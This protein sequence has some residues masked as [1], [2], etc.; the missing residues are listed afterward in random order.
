[1]SQEAAIAAMRARPGFGVIPDPGTLER[2]A[3]VAL[4][5]RVRPILFDEPGA[6]M[7][8]RKPLILGVHGQE[9]DGSLLVS[10]IKID[11]P[12]EPD[13]YTDAVVAV[14][15]TIETVALLTVVGVDT[16]PKGTHLATTTSYQVANGGEFDGFPGYEFALLFAVHRPDADPVILGLSEDEIREQFDGKRLNLSTTE[17]RVYGEK[18]IERMPVL[19]VNPFE[20]L[21]S[22]VDAVTASR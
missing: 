16:F 2:S 13:E 17:F 12:D 6:R 4:G 1:M 5:R 20:I 7:K 11:D 3:A 10:L 8:L 9:P 14:L 19:S 21:K 22:R 15:Q 18:N